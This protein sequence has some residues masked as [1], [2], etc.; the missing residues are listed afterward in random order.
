[1]QRLF[2]AGL[3][4]GVF[5]GLVSCAQDVREDS[6]VWDH[7]WKQ[8]IYNLLFTNIDDIDH[9]RYWVKREPE[10]VDG[11]PHQNACIEVAVPAISS[12][13]YLAN[14]NTYAFNEVKSCQGDYWLHSN[15]VSATTEKAFSAELW[16]SDSGV[17]IHHTNQDHVRLVFQSLFLVNESVLTPEGKNILIRMIEELRG[18]PVESL[19]VYGVAD[20]SGSYSSNRRLANARANSVKYYLQTEGMGDTPIMLRGSVENGLPT[21]TQRISQRRFIIEIKFNYDEK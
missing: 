16:K 4:V 14:I 8:D 19:R 9:V 3:I 10:Y 18:Q 17:L 6:I 7:E 1:M 11:S 20:S 15:L 21:A 5:M 13:Y 2:K 12:K